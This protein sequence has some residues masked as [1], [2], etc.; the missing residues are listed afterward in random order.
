MGLLGSGYW[1]EVLTARHAAA[2]GDGGLQ[3]QETLLQVSTNHCFS[4]YLKWTES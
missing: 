1:Q 3:R 2:E 4:L